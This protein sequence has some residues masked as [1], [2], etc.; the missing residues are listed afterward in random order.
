M[1]FDFDFDFAFHRKQIT[2][3]RLIVGALKLFSCLRL[4]PGHHSSLA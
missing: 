2:K 4:E 1:A 3:N